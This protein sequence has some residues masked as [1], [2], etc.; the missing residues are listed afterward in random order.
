MSPPPLNPPVSIQFKQGI[1]HGYHQINGR[2]KLAV[3]V[4][5]SMEGTSK[6]TDTKLAEKDKQNAAKIASNKA[7]S[8]KPKKGHYKD[9]HFKK[10]PPLPTQ[11]VDKAPFKKRAKENR[12]NGC[13]QL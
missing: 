11:R 4:T 1:H 8:G 9:E 3:K 6:K 10:Y 13:V 2:N 12:A 7:K 5:R